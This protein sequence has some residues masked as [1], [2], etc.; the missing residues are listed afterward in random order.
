MQ[1]PGKLLL[2]VD[3]VIFFDGPLQILQIDSG[4]QVVFVPK[5]IVKCRTLRTAYLTQLCYP[6]LGECLCCQQ[7][8]QRIGKGVFCTLPNRYA[9]TPFV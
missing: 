1:K 7:C 5:M 8:F 2:I 9:I 3:S 6:D 4:D